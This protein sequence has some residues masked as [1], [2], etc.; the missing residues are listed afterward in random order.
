MKLTPIALLLPAILMATGTVFAH[1]KQADDAHAEA[2]LD[3]AQHDWGVAAR[4]EDA[5]RVVEITM[6]DSMRFTPETI[7]VKKGETVTFRLGNDGQLFHEFVLGTQQSLEEHAAL[8]AEYPG[9]E[10]DEPYMAHVVPAETSD[11]TWTFNVDE[12]VKFG[13][14]I[15]GHYESGMHGE[16]AVTGKSV[17]NN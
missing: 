3:T 1:V 12:T 10:H 2:P 13:C 17:A 9:M 11:I 16:I 8:M 14:L 5:D 6:D 15:A 7:H 4:P